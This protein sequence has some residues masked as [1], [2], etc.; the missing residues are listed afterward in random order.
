MLHPRFPVG[1]Y[2]LRAKIHPVDF[3]MRYVPRLLARGFEIYGEEK[4]KV[5]RVNRNT[6]TI[7]F[8]ISSGIDWFDVKAVVAYGDLEVSFKDIRRALRRKENYIKLADGTIGQIPE[9]WIERDKH[10]FALG[11]RPMMGCD[12]RTIM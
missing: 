1:H 10:L 7:S 11:R 9:A 6:P 3:L 4:L 2:L 8:N 5:G 12:Y